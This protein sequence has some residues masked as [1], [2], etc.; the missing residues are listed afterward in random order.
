MVPLSAFPGFG[1]PSNLPSVA[2]PCHGTEEPS[3]AAAGVVTNMSTAVYINN[4]DDRSNG[5]VMDGDENNGEEEEQ[6]QQ[7]RGATANPAA[8][9]DLGILSLDDEDLT[10]VIFLVHNGVKLNCA[11]DN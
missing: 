3:F 8:P 6:L 9:V 5:N 2:S 10:L 4:S 7:L 11:E 1:D